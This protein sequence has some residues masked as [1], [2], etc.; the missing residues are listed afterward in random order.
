MNHRYASI[1]LLAASLSSGCSTE[2]FSL[3]MLTWR[4]DTKQAELEPAVAA[5]A[6]EL[7]RHPLF[8]GTG[9]R[10]DAGPYLNA[11]VPWTSNG[12]SALSLPRSL[13]DALDVEGWVAAS[14]SIAVE[15]YDFSWMKR[16]HEFDHWTIE[17]DPRFRSKEPFSII[18]ADIPDLPVLATWAKLRLLDGLRRGDLASARAEV[19]QLARLLATIERHVAVIYA[20][21][22]VSYRVGQ[23]PAAEDAAQIRDYLQ[24][25]LRLLLPASA[26]AELTRRLRD[27]HAPGYCAFTHEALWLIYANRPRAE[28]KLSR[29]D[30]SYALYDRLMTDPSIRCRW[31]TLREAW[32]ERGTRGHFLDPV[33]D[34]ASGRALDARSKALLDAVEER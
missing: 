15:S 8:T 16:L 28:G 25:Q 33:T 7:R 14:S 11:I 21:R 4:E 26:K 22:I 6:A 27:T 30:E 24:L 18:D 20:G 12:T 1:A 5:R 19:T 23:E 17:S 3:L 2:P 9:T 32:I 34:E 10:A 13:E 29:I 31:P